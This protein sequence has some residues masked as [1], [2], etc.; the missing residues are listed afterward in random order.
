MSF[1]NG[2]IVMILKGSLILKA[3]VGFEGFLGVEG[4]PK[5]FFGREAVLYC[6]WESR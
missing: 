3:S 4:F 5:L 2:S 1:L 6:L